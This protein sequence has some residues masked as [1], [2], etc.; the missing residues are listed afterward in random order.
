MKPTTRVVLYALPY[1]IS[2]LLF[3][4]AEPDAF[5]QDGFGARGPAL[6]GAY[7]AL[8]D[9]VD[10]IY[11][12]PAGLSRLGKSEISTMYSPNQIE[13]HRSYVAA[14]TPLGSFGALAAGWYHLGSN[15]IELTN[16]TQPIGFSDLSNDAYYIS[17]G[18]NVSPN[19][20]VGVTAKRLS[21]SFDSFSESGWG[22]DAGA[23]YRLRWFSAGL[24]VTDLVQTHLTGN[25]ILGN[26][27]VSEDVPRR[28][29]VGGALTWPE[30]GVN[31]EQ[32]W[33]IPV[34]FNLCLD[35]LIPLEG[36]DSKEARPGGEVWILDHVAIRGGWMPQIGPTWGAGIKF[37]NVSFD[38]AILIDP[39]LT[40]QNRFSFAF[41]F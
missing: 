8:A 38:Y 25:S 28:V 32:A 21:F 6:A 10:G 22:A 14:G 27:S 4:A 30:E 36:D 2:A 1:T 35:G 7:T 39:D 11:W 20:A 13:V 18:G 31:P 40:N 29:H 19:L 12:N 9:D 3:A 33:G 23:Q 17:W 34:R 41:Y 26:G 5:V 24:A 16:E 37:A 15:G